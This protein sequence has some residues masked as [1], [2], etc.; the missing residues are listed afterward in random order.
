MDLLLQWIVQAAALTALVSLFLWKQRA[1]SAS[2]R[3]RVWWTTLALVLALP[4]LSALDLPGVGALL[5][6]TPVRDAVPAPQDAMPSAAGPD[7]EGGGVLS[8]TLLLLGGCGLWMMRGSWRLRTALVE[9]DSAKRECKPF[10]IVRERRLSL[11]KATRNRGRRATLAMS[12]HVRA[13]GVLGLGYPR[14][15]LNGALVVGLTDEELDMVVLHEYAHVQRRDDVLAAV[16]MG[17]FAL[18]GWHPAVWWIDRQLR[19]EREVACD[20]WV[21]QATSSPRTYARCLTH[22]ADLAAGPESLLVP[23]GV[24]RSH[25]S[26]RVVR[27]LD[28]ERNTATRP[29]GL[30]WATSAAL[31]TMASIGLA[32]RQTALS[33]QPS[34]AR[35]APALIAGIDATAPTEGATPP[36]PRATRMAGPASRAASL[37][38]D[39]SL[40]HDEA[41]ADVEGQADRTLAVT[42]LVPQT[43]A[44]HASAQTTY[45]IEPRSDAV[46]PL[47]VAAMHA[48][49]EAAYEVETT[50]SDTAAADRLAE[51]V[52][53]D[54]DEASWGDSSRRAVVN[55]SR[56]ASRSIADVSVD[57]GSAVAGAGTAAYAGS[58]KVAVK[59][60]RFFSRIGKT[61]ARPF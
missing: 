9:L 31:L 40:A 15:A 43:D 47:T 61:L 7:A 38:A 26:T 12:D 5:D 54:V 23:A 35:I 58:R 21:V 3:Y 56:V 49:N 25:L 37:R 44:V 20:D 30:A 10:P 32:G 11:W 57:A 29:S 22:I 4:L 2:M 42:A 36:A 24:R 59:T 45:P 27:L 34:L 39:V 52:S 50:R 14:I 55:A 19:V 33:I 46:A 18:V 17:I 13:A 60:A 41:P 16:Q 6:V 1:V 53:A 51:D 8:M 28:R 48:V